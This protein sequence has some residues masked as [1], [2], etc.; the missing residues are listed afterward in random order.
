M[1][2]LA[3]R[4]GAFRGTNPVRMVKF[5]DE[6]SDVLR[7]LSLEEEE[8]LLS[9]C[10]P[11]LQDLVVFAINTGLRAG[12]ILNL[13]WEEVDLEASII[14]PKVRKNRKQLEIPLNDAAQRVVH[15]WHGMKKCRYVFSTLRLETRSRIFGLG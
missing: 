15:A 13:G 7:V 3:E 1:F 6:D 14:V 2:N 5:F 12:D 9:H 11:Y 8:R 4:W 10:S